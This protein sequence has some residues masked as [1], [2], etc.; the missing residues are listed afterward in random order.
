MKKKETLA[1]LKRILKSSDVASK[2]AARIT[3]LAASLPATAIPVMEGEM[4]PKNP[5]LTV[6]LMDA[7]YTITGTQCYEGKLKDI[8]AFAEGFG[9]AGEELY[10]SARLALARLPS[11]AKDNF[12]E[13]NT[14]SFEIHAMAAARVSKGTPV[15]GK[16]KASA[17]T[18]LQKRITIIVHGTWA[19]DGQWWKPGGDFFEYVKKDLRRTDLYGEQDQFKWSGKN[20]DSSRWEASAELHAWLNA[21]PSAEINVFAHSHGA[22][23]AMLATRRGVTFDRL[24]MLSPP[25]RE[26][27]YADWSK[28]KAAYNIQAAFD[29]VVAIA[30]GGSQFP[31]WCNVKHKTLKANGHSASHDP[32]VWRDEKLADFVGL[33]WPLK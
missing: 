6:A 33:P 16:A 2:K 32:S 9:D 11:L 1:E 12:G 23:I 4:G 22:N 25:V 27:Y 17:K 3:K 19:A 28:V 5:L 26:E 13:L 30:Q 18:A 29:P 15:A 14:R 7:C 8:L 31:S 21:H 10:M 20:R 24:V